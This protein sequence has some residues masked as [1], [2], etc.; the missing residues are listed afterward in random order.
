MNLR[1]VLGGMERLLA[2]FSVAGSS[3]TTPEGVRV[4]VGILCFEK[5]SFDRVWKDP[6]LSDRKSALYRLLRLGFELCASRSRDYIGRGPLSSIS[7]NS[8][9]C[10]SSARGPCETAGFVVE[11]K[12]ESV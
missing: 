3:V 11:G 12:R 8:H 5:F 4:R 9:L 7:L 1:Q 2:I 6:L 10:W